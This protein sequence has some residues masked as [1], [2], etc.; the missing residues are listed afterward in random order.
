[1]STYTLI[2]L[3]VNTPAMGSMMTTTVEF[4]SQ[5]SCEVALVTLAKAN[6]R[7]YSN[8]MSLKASGCFAK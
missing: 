8:G 7:D 5:K 4:N 6:T 1:M 3:W 2:M